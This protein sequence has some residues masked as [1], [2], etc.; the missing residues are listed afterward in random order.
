MAEPHCHGMSEAT[1]RKGSGKRATIP[2]EAESVVV[3]EVAPA[4]SAPC[5]AC[6]FLRRKC[7]SGC[8]FA[9][10]FGSDQGAAKFAA[11]HKVASL[12]AELA[13]VQNQLI[14]SQLAVANALQSSQQQQQQHHHHRQ[15][16]E[17]HMAFLRP[18]YSN[19]S[20]ASNNLINISN[21]ASNFELVAET[22]A[23]N[24]SQSM[25]HLQLSM[26]CHDDEDDE[27][28]SRIPPIFANQIIHSS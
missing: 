8:I 26:P 18:A 13:M 7:V 14:N 4:P 6:K 20:S 11:V 5:G 25:D 22:A 9:P 19:N 1:R 23:P 12:Q 27:Q 17:Q 16:H 2:V 15:Q 28:D 24:S 3:H 21:F 10:H